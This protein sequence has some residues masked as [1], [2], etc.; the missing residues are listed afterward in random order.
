MGF[1]QK[2]VYQEGKDDTGIRHAMPREGAMAADV[3]GT[4]DKG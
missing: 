4:P 1:D 3:L 2:G